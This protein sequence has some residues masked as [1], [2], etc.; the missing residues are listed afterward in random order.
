M[1]LDEEQESQN[2]EDRRG[3]RISPGVAGGGIGTIAMVLIALFFGIDPSMLFQS[4]VE[5]TNAP[6]KLSPQSQGN[7][8]QDEMAHFVARVLGSTERIWTEI[9][10]TGGNPYK[11]PTLVLFSDTVQSACGFAQAASGPFYCGPDQKVYIDLGFY[12]DLR[13]RYQAPGDFA[14]AYV[15]AHEVGHHVQNLLGIMNKV[16]TSQSHAT[17]QQQANALSVRLEL[18]ADCFAGVWANHANREDNILEEGDIEEGLNAAA[19]IGDDR[20]QKRAGGY[21]VP[22][23]FTHGSAEQRVQWFRRGIQSGELKHCDTFA[24]GPLS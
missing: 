16:R 15:I 7:S 5:Q 24:T 23:G 19:Q 10:E 9:F 13:Q 14:Q 6:Q 3:F 11:K 18:Q 2:I 17:T 1:R 21:V 22:E 20:M 8:G 4:Q 12:R